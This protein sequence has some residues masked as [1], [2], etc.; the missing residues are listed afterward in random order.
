MPNARAAGTSTTHHPGS[1]GNRQS[2]TGGSGQQSSEGMARE[3]QNQNQYSSGSARRTSFNTSTGDNN[4]LYHR[5]MNSSGSTSSFL[6]HQQPFNSTTPAQRPPNLDIAS[7]HQQHQQ[8]MD[9][10][11]FQSSAVDPVS[12]FLAEMPTQREDPTRHVLWTELIKLKTRTLELQIAE[13][14]RKE[15][16]AELEIMRLKAGVAA[17]SEPQL[18]SRQLNNAQSTQIDTAQS[19]EITGPSA[20]VNDNVY[21]MMGQHAQSLAGPSRHSQPPQQ[22]Q[23]VFGGNHGPL[24]PFD[25]EAMMQSDNLDSLLSWLPDFGDSTSQDL[26]PFGS[27]TDYQ[28]STGDR[29]I[30]LD[31]NLMAPLP[32]QP[33]SQPQAQTQTRDHLSLSAWGAQP[34]SSPSKRRSPSPADSEPPSQPAAKKSKRGTEKKIVVEQTATCLICSKLL[35]RVMIR[36]PKSQIPEPIETQLRCPTCVPVD[37]PSALPDQVASGAS[38]SG[39]IGTVETRK[40]I[41]ASLEMDDEDAKLKNRRCWCDVCQRIVGSGQIVGGEEKESLIGMAEVVC[42]GCDS[43]YQRCTDCGG[44]GGPRVGIGKWRMK[45][46]FHPGR[47]TCSLSHTRLGDRT[48]ELGVHVTPTDFTPEQMKEVLARCKAL[49]NE[50]TLSRLA[51]PEMLEVDL[52]PGLDNPLRDYAD[53]DDMVTRNWPSREAMIRADGLDPNRFKRLLSLIWS[54][55][56]PRRTVRTVDLEEEWSKQAEDTDDDLSTVLAHVKRTNVVIPSGSELIGMWGGEWDMQN[57]SLLISTFI[58]FEGADGEDS[59]AL[60]VGEMITKVQALQQE[61]NAE[62]TA[63]AEK[64]GKQPTLLPPCAHLWTVSGGY[65]PL[66]RERFA[67]ILIRKRSFVHVEEYLTRHPEFIESI[68]AR[69]VGLHPDIVRSLPTQASNADG[70][71]N[72]N[73][74]QARPLILVRWLGKEWDHQKILE[75]KR[76]EFGQKKKRTKSKP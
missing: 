74:Q 28:T 53:V 15:R 38:S 64:E 42:A 11:Q 59:T 54:H 45:Q 19:N 35:A 13:A 43:K 60:S 31:P 29:P 12:K 50:K 9:Q 4:Q 25:L 57:G 51:V 44:G 2:G 10:G 1:A 52:P 73:Q 56:K 75:I 66:V 49:W 70:D 47:K 61:I 16:E 8:N 55:S 69:P 20:G 34:Q 30:S 32:P 65:I 23:N 27:S 40:R 3:G 17:K 68:K 6:G 7:E 37:Q 71:G 24:T 26:Q 63:Q 14:R 46:V 76:M 39:P 67:D 21:S 62:R 58:P 72:D 18:D 48:R 22:T 5:G 41:R 33:L 36:A